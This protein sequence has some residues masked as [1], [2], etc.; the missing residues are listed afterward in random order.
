[1][2]ER[3][4]VDYIFVSVVAVNWIIVTVLILLGY[5]F[6]TAVLYG[7]VFNLI[8]FIGALIIL[9]ARKRKR[10]FE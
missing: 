7:I 5:D 9:E 8:E 10:N 6:V 1:M 3:E 4:M 2:T